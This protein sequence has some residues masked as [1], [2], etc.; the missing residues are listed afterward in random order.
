MKY[1]TLIYKVSVVVNN[2]QIFCICINKGIPYK[3]KK[4]TNLAFAKITVKASNLK[5]KAIKEKPK[6]RRARD[7]KRWN[8]LVISSSFIILNNIL[9]FLKMMND[10]KC[11]PL[12]N[13][14]DRGVACLPT[15]KPITKKWL[16]TNNE[17]DK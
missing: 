8:N 9:N 7:C 14:W 15:F 4:Q 10:E 12:T 13:Y 17:N 6:I 1:L 2:Y 5:F 11:L 16:F 3:T